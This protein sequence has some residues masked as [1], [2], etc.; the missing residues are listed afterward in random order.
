MSAAEGRH[1]RPDPGRSPPKPIL[2]DGGRAPASLAGSGLPGR[3]HEDLRENLQPRGSNQYDDQPVAPA[4]GFPITSR[5]DRHR[6]RAT[7]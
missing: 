2:G 1:P 6:T 5:A 7:P 3:A 4:G